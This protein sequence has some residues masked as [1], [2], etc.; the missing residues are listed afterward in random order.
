MLNFREE[1]NALR[2]KL[3]VF[4]GQT[5]HDTRFVQC[6]F[7]YCLAVVSQTIDSLSHRVIAY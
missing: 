2:G 3:Y 7:N 1:G 5:L 6:A 4:C